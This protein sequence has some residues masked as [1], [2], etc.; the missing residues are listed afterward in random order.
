MKLNIV[1]AREY[2]ILPN[3][4]T[5]Q[6]EQLQK[7][8]LDIEDDSMIVFEQ[9]TYQ[10]DCQFLIENKKNLTLCGDK[11]M[12]VSHYDT[13]MKV[14]DTPGMFL[15]RGLDNLTICNIVV[16][17]D[18]PT[19]TTGRVISKD[20]EGGTYVFRPLCNGKITGQERIMAQNSFDEELTPDYHLFCYEKNPYDLLE[21]GDI[22]IHL[23]EEPQEQLKRLEVG[24]LVS[25][26]H[27]VYGKEFFIFENCDNVKL[28][29]VTV[30]SSPGPTVRV[31]PRCSN[32]TFERFCVKLPEGSERLFAANADGIH[33]KGLT[34]KLILKDCYFEHLG[35]DALNIHSRA[36]MVTRVD[37][38]NKVISCIS[39]WEREPLSA[40][41]ARCGDVIEVY[42]PKEFLVKAKI[43]V[44][45][46]EDGNITY[47]ILEGEVQE[48]DVLANTA[49][50]ASVHVENCMV[51]NSRARG[52]LIQ[53]RD[54]VVENCKFEGLSLAGVL[55]SPDIE[56]WYEVGPARNVLIQNNTFT[57]CAYAGAV[58]NLGNILV[59]S[60]HGSEYEAYP[61]GVHKNIIVRDNKF[62]D[63]PVSAIFVSSTEGIEVTDNEFLNC[64]YEQRGEELPGSNEIVE[65]QNCSQVIMENN[66]EK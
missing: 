38:D 31:L 47:D 60:S 21:N 34:G 37:V 58:H 65:L 8:F 45:G 39:G 4:K 61:C 18:Y 56:Y 14:A 64:C 62:V 27:I 11:T 2:G 66:H 28:E 57:K 63:S 15:F 46:F 41:W 44:T 43:Y 29:D 40:D 55:I 32:F 19:N 52:I 22:R 35:D 49:Y 48:G 26:R 16:T 30:Y 42:H 1:S 25:L 12:F 6:K 7:L 17:T 3:Q 59:K 24:Q 20:I 13:Q 23:T 51:K 54:V 53:S 10:M 5:C 33:I 9:G 50:F 36:A